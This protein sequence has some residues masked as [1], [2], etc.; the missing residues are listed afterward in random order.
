M[1]VEGLHKFKLGQVQRGDMMTDWLHDKWVLIF[2][3][4][5]EWQ[6]RSPGHQSGILQDQAKDTMSRNQL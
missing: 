5:N 2:F 6:L 1:L 4:N 3:R